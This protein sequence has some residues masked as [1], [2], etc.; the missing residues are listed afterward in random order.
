MK[1]HPSFP[2]VSFQLFLRERTVA[3]MVVL[4]VSV[5]WACVYSCYVVK[6]G[7]PSKAVGAPRNPAQHNTIGDFKNELILV[8]GHRLQVFLEYILQLLVAFGFEELCFFHE[9]FVLIE[10]V[11]FWAV[12]FLFLFGR[13]FG[14]LFGFGLLI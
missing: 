8:S 14:D 13:L 3:V 10:G 5:S 1:N 9:S 12:L 6:F 11:S 7:S 2:W 4:V